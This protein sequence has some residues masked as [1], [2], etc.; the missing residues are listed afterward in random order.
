MPILTSTDF[1]IAF[2]SST[3]QHFLGKLKS[4]VLPLLLRHIGFEDSIEISF[5]VIRVKIE[6]SG[7]GNNPVSITLC[8]SRFEQAVIPSGD[9]SAVMLPILFN[10][11]FAQPIGLSEVLSIDSTVD[12]LFAEIFHLQIFHHKLQGSLLALRLLN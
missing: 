8:L 6:P 3:M 11:I 12:D 5:D 9:K 10:S 2:F 1:C 4:E 7:I